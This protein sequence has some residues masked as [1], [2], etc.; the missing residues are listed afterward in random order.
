MD[1]GK[2]FTFVFDDEE[3][4]TKIGLAG[5]I[6]L[7]PLVGQIILLGWGFEVTRRVI[8]GDPEP[9]PDWSDFGGHLMKGFQVFI[10]ALV[11]MLPIILFQGCANI[12]ALFIGEGD[13]TLVTVLSILMACFGC[14]TFLYAIF[15]GLIL[16]AGIG[17]F[18]AKGELKAAFSFGEIFGLVRDNFGTY[19]LVL[20]GYLLAGFIGSLG[21]IACVIGV[22]FTQAYSI[23]VNGHLMGQAY[24]VATSGGVVES[25][26]VVPDIDF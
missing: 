21:V 8:N 7:I 4:I 1:F 10:V 5:L 6:S 22:L 15:V 9:L 26:E 2:S 12:P 14:I 19:A 25:E 3:W 24:N 17:S 18:A 13:D 23:V 16:P 20:L 11:Y